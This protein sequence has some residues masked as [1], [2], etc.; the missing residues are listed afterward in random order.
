MSPISPY[1]TV[2][3]VK[4]F[5]CLSVCPSVTKFDPNYFMTFWQEIITLT[6]PIRRGVWNLPHKFHLYLIVR[7]FYVQDLVYSGEFNWKKKNT[8]I[9]KMTYLCH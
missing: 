1:E 6:H 8:V 2:Y 9:I 5:V 7:Y 3:G 4:E